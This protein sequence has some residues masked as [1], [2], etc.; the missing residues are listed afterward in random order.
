MSVDE[1]VPLFLMHICQAPSPW[2]Q[3][4]VVSETAYPTQVRQAVVGLKKYVTFQSYS[5]SGSLV[6]FGVFA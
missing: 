3:D 6:V 5:K 1:K 2:W 4:G